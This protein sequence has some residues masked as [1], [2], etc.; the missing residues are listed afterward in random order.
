M[1]TAVTLGPAW[2]CSEIYLGS[3]WNI[4]VFCLKHTCLLSEIK[5]NPFQSILRNKKLKLSDTCHR[6]SSNVYIYLFQ[7][8]LG[9]FLNSS[10]QNRKCISKQRHTMYYLQKA[11]T[12]S[13]ILVSRSTVNIDVNENV[14]AIRVISPYVIVYEQ[15]SQ[16]A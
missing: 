11:I 7:R 4:F 8:F 6:K 9:A 14:S 15:C 12:C 16:N 13:T 5:Q 3:V 2:G 1:L 10:F